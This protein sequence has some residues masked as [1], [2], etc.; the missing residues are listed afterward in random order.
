MKILLI[1]A[2]LALFVFLIVKAQSI[3]GAEHNRYQRDLLQLK[4]SDASLDQA[5]LRTRHRLFVSYDPLNLEL[6]RIRRLY[7]SVETPP[8][9]IDRE[10]VREMRVE[11]ELFGEELEREN[12]LIQRFKSHNAIL[13]NSQRYF[14]VATSNFTQHLGPSDSDL[15]SRLVQFTRDVLRYCL[16]PSEELD[17]QARSQLNSLTQIAMVRKSAD[18]RDLITLLNHSRTIL[19][20]Q[21]VVDRLLKELIDIPTTSHAAKLYSLQASRYE[22]ALQSSNFFRFCLYVL[23]V[24]VL[25]LIIFKLQRLTRD[26]KIA[27][28]NVDQENQVRRLAEAQLLEAR[29]AALDS[30]RLKSEFLANMSHE[31]R[32]PMN[33]VIGMTGLLLDTN[34]SY[35]Q[36]D[37]AETIRSSADSLLAIINDILDFSKIEAGKL[38]F[39]ILDF[40]VR[41]AVEDSVELLAERA[42]AKQVELAAHT[43]CNFA[44]TLRGDQ[45]RLRQVLTNLIGN[46][47]KFTEQG[48]VIVRA[49]KQAETDE[50]ITLRFSVK[51]TGIG[52]HPDAQKNLFQAFMQADGSTTRKYGGTGLGLCISRQ[53]V[54]LM[55]GEI[56]VDSIPGQGSTFWFT[57]VFEKQQGRACLIDKASLNDLRVLIVDDNETNRRIL[58]GQTRCWGMVPTDCDSGARALELLREAT[59]MGRQ[60]DLAILDLMMPGMDGFELARAIKSDP[61]T[62]SMPL[63]MLTSFGD[64]QHGAKA[65]ELGVAMY[66]PKPV[67]QSQLHDCLSAVMGRSRET[68][69]TLASQ[70]I[71]RDPELENVLR[72]KRILLAEDNI[73]NQKVAI[74]QLKKLGVFTDAVANG[75]EV[76]EALKSIPYDLVLMDCQMPEMD[77][78]EATAEI[79]RREGEGLSRHTPIV[80]MTANAL[81]GDRDRCLAAGMDDYISKPVKSGELERVLEKYL[82]SHELIEV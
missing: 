60:Y 68:V 42:A 2:L 81:E 72:R 20:E 74:R 76:L 41:S 29:D 34:L 6:E 47:V 35:E 22:A 37:F 77:G 51:D 11:W 8:R 50:S 12:Q 64:R 33:G 44:T 43:S 53:L 62:A 25:G 78:Y 66:L 69:Q 13:I 31:I 10:G 57:A 32:T 38:S 65:R 3:D 46:A 45:G 40:D 4:E 15:S 79:R 26:L 16:A 36:R 1:A 71:A 80:A 19:D 17:E 52:I 14:P 21:R 30:A 58:C 27:K 70:S 5:I 61:D 7:A 28:E 75:R 54:E 9:Y 48:E 56:G 39:E 55:G 23:S 63:V 82:L 24:A 59:S 67:R 49:E 73:V 18:T